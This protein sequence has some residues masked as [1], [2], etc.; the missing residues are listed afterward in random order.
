MA[1]YF[2]PTNADDLLLLNSAVRVN[3]ELINVANPTEDDIQ[4][5]Y[6]VYDEDDEEYV[7]K[8]RGYTVDPDDAGVLFK[9]AYKQTI[10][11][12]ISW[13]LLNYSSS[14]N[15]KGIKRDKRGE[16]EQQYF[17]GFNPEELPDYIFTRLA[18]FNI[19]EP[20]WGI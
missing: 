2:D 11:D 7:V 4:Q 17:D 6:T 1:Y 20:I 16:R 13:R 10:A 15:H 3:S 9:K 5:L 8:L 14:D 12:A 18:L 19:N